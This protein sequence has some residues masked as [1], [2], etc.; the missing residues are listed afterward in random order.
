MDHNAASVSRSALIG[1]LLLRVQS[2][3]MMTVRAVCAVALGACTY[4]APTTL[5]DGGAD[6]ATDTPD[7]PPNTPPDTTP[8]AFWISVVGADAGDDSLVKT[9]P[10]AA[11]GDS[12]AVSSRTIDSG[13]GALEFSTS[14]NQL[15]KAVGLS[16]GD[17]NQNFTDIDFCLVLGANR[18]VSVFEK[19]IAL[20][21]IG[22][23]LSDDVFR[24]E[25][26]SG[27]VRYLRNGLVI[28]TSLQAPVYPILVDAAL[29]S[30]GATIKNVSLQ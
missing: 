22:N 12:G 30:P 28:F 2:L 11:W 26:T 5:S 27:V 16:N 7:G 21:V 18:K 25:I 10:V 3:V 19:G 13:D 29:F 20:Q 14:E 17:T 1:K 9:S 15:G 6:S 4:T 23:Y 24:I 8:V